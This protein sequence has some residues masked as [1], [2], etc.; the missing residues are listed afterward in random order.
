MNGQLLC[1]LVFAGAAAAAAVAGVAWLATAA[2]AAATPFL[3]M[4]VLFALGGIRAR[5]DGAAGSIH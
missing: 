4:G 2:L 3:L 5:H 1:G